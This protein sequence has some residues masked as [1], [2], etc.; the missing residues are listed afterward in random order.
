MVAGVSDPG[1]MA[2]RFEGEAMKRE[3]CPDCI[4]GC[5]VLRRWE[6]DGV[7]HAELSR[8]PCLTCEGRGYVG[9]RQFKLKGAQSDQTAASYGFLLQSGKVPW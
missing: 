8:E 1:R 6:V 5:Q 4:R 7:P 2:P 9:P 3:R